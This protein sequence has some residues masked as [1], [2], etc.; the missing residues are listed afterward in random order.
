MSG[1]RWAIYAAVAGV[2]AGAF[3]IG[4]GLYAHSAQPDF[5]I[6]QFFGVY[7]D[8]FS[9][10]HALVG[11]GIVMVAGGLLTLKWPSVGAII[12]CVAAMIGLIFTYDRGQYRW[13][14]LVYYWWGPWLFA[15]ITGI[16]AGYAAYKNVPQI[17]EKLADAR[18]NHNLA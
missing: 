7:A 10:V 9:G 16:L 4:G 12:V 15:W 3:A 5:G 2:I 17:D 13:I 6:P 8:Y 18:P 14:P 11:L 1:Q